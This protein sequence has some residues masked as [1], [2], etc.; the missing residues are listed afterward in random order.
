[1]REQGIG[2]FRKPNELFGGRGGEKR[3]EEKKMTKAKSQ[4]Q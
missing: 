3:R 1:M 2:N 4:Q